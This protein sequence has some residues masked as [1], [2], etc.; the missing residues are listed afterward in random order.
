MGKMDIQCLYVGQKSK[1]YTD[2]I[3]VL[4]GFDVKIQL[5]LIET[6]K[7]YVLLALKRLKESG[8]IFISDDIQFSLEE[9]SDLV[10]QH[11]P[12][13]IVVI[14]SDKATSTVLKEKINNIRFSRLYFRAGND[15]TR[16]F[17]QCL[18]QTVQFK[19]EFR[20]CK[21]LLGTSEKR[22]QWLVESSREAISYITR[23]L[24]LYAN[25]PYLEL[26]NV[27][28]I[29]KLRSISI[30][31]FFAKDEYPLFKTFLEA[32][33]RR[34]NIN[35][36]LVLSMQK[37]NG[38]FFRA[39]VHLIPSVYNGKKCL[40][41]WVSA[42][43]KPPVQT[44]STAEQANLEKNE[45]EQDDKGNV[46]ISRLFEENNEQQQGIPNPF[47]V[48][49]KEPVKKTPKVDPSAVILEIIKRKEASLFAQKLTLMK[50]DSGISEHFLLSLEIDK[51][52]KKG[53]KNLLFKPETVTL[54][55]QQAV[56]WDKV[57]FTRLFQVLTSKNKLDNILL[58]DV[59][60]VSIAD[61]EFS[62]WLMSEVAILGAKAAHLGF[63]LP[64]PL[65]EKQKELVFLF[66]QELRTHRCKIVLDNYLTSSASLNMLKL[67]RPD[68]VRF[69]LK[70]VQQA[71]GSDK[72]E[73][74]LGNAIRQFESKNIKVIT[75]CSFSPQM[76]KNF[77]L[78]GVSFCQE[79]ATK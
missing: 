25:S 13:A 7:K 31:D 44:L 26:F 33:L 54:L 63:L 36:S 24:H 49:N 76:R 9:L 45:P 46:S 18:L 66:S 32:Q 11:A 79:K 47:S 43:D 14:L 27:E 60:I 2:L 70:W 53:I 61:N 16:L 42:L 73:L 77:A 30:K 55:Q 58:I 17:L 62:Q 1:L 34:H 74:G 40:Q 52:Q 4:D 69:S 72:R 78:A 10:W 39:N 57:K 12:D 19:K 23:D 35:R 22:C 68:Y 64:C 67:I 21:R 59:Q 71:E 28:S 38:V 3:Q 15:K 8:L 20:R 48:L 41:L 29:Q 51:E 56:F 75:P 65:N 37:S 5:K 6:E 50:K